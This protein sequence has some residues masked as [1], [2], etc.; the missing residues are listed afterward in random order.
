MRRL[1]ADGN[2]VRRGRWLPDVWRQA[3]EKKAMES[4]MSKAGQ[5][6]H[7]NIETDGPI[8][9]KGILAFGVRRAVSTQRRL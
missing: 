8:R 3:Y 2:T 4:A 1:C 6:G 5:T 7:V 9:A